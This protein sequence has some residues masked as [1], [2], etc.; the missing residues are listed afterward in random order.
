MNELTQAEIILTD[1]TD[2]CA[3]SCFYEPCISNKLFEAIELIR[4]AN[5]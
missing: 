5:K 1:L 4:K 3:G 2:Q